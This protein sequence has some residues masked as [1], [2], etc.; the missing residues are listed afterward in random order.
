MRTEQHETLY[1][2]PAPSPTRRGINGW[3]VATVALA[4]ILVIVAGYA[5]VRIGWTS[6]E[7]DETKSSLTA[8]GTAMADLS[9][10]L[11]KTTADL[12]KATAELASANSQTAACRTASAQLKVVGDDLA[13]ALAQLWR[14][15]GKF[16]WLYSSYIRSVMNGVNIGAVQPALKAA[17]ICANGAVSAL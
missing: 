6:G 7:L 3:L 8:A 17:R 1:V 11:E 12:D 13:T 15:T 9:D 16:R 5:F 14:D 4:V 10:E 2:P